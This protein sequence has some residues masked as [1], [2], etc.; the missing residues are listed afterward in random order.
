MIQE[1]RCSNGSFPGATAAQRTRAG[2]GVF[3]ET[4]P[5]HQPGRAEGEVGLI[6]AEGKASLRQERAQG[7]R[8]SRRQAQGGSG[9]SVRDDGV[10]K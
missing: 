9:E 5:D 4:R 3:L 6:L 7:T 8:G 1:E 2:G 10:G